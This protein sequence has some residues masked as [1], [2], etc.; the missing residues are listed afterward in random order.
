GHT[1]C[2]E[3]REVDWLRTKEKVDAGADVVITQL[4]YDNADFHAFEAA[5]RRHGVAVPIV[6]GVLPILSTPQIKRFT[7][8]CGAKLPAAL[9]AE[10]EG[11][12]EDAPAAARLGIEHAT[13]QCR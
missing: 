5:L 7:A 8:L 13:A 1:E 3:G 10:L 2:V 9:L 12:V 4:F 11:A 6:P